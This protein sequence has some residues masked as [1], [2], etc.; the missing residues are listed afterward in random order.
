VK[1]RGVVGIACAGLVSEMDGEV[2]EHLRAWWAQDQPWCLHSAAW[3]RRHWERT[4]ILD[5]ESADTMAD[6]WEFWRAWQKTIA[7]GSAVEIGALEA[8]RGSYLGYV[9]VVGRRRADAPLYEPVG[10]VQMEYAKKR[11]LREESPEVLA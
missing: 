9:R 4:G 6:G 5:V 11:L 7:P 1:P 3:W 10:S 2:P 8:D